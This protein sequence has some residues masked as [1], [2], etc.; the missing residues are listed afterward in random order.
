MLCAWCASRGSGTPELDDAAY[1]VM[2]LLRAMGV[3]AVGVRWSEDVAEFLV[4]VADDVI[5][6][7]ASIHGLIDTDHTELARSLARQHAWIQS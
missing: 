5:S 6:R 2:V 3:F 4:R 1:V 7:R